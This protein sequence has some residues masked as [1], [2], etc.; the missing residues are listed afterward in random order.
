M[1]YTKE[2]WCSFSRASYPEN[3]VRNTAETTMLP[4]IVGTYSNLGKDLYQQ[5]LLTILLLSC[6]PEVRKEG[7]EVMLLIVVIQRGYLIHPAYRVEVISSP[8]D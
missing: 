3:D 7:S 5:S 6:W 8:L 2:I 4:G 1:T